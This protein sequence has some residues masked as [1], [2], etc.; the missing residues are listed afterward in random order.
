MFGYLT[1]NVSMTAAKAP[2]FPTYA[3]GWNEIFLEIKMKD[4]CSDLLMGANVTKMAIRKRTPYDD[5]WIFDYSFMSPHK[6]FVFPHDASGVV[7]R[8]FNRSDAHRKHR[9]VR[10]VNTT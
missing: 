9:S 6:E 2:T 5:Q 8:I 1:A 3:I 7:T 4:H 10:R